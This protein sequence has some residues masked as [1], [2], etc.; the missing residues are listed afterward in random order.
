[1]TDPAPPLPPSTAIA[2]R[3]RGVRPLHLALDV[4]GAVG[5]VM[6]LYRF[7]QLTRGWM[8]YDEGILLTHTWVLM[9]GG[10]PFRDFY[11]QYPPGIY[12]LLAA[13]WKVVGVSVL[14][15]RILSDV[16]RASIALVAGVIG[17]RLSGRRFALLPA[18]VVAVWLAV[19]AGPPFAWFVALLCALLT[20]L[21]LERAFV[22]RSR[23][24]LAGSGALLALTFSFRHDLAL[25]LCVALVPVAAYALFIVRPRPVAPIAALRA[26]GLL[27]AGA[28]PVLV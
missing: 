17:G 10:W 4:I 5:L 16:I 27:A 1:M 3:R 2:P 9:H 14:S 20:A 26:L 22:R 8:T 18:G 25:Y 6:G 21:G 7:V 13:L 28:A 19:I 11:T 15:D 23:G 24:W 12:L